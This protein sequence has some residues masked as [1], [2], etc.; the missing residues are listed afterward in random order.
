[1]KVAKI[2]Q[3]EKLTNLRFFT[4][5]PPYTYCLNIYC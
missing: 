2:S 1:M 5:V 4:L 3:T